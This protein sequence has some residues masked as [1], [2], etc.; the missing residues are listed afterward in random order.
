TML[1]TGCKRIVINGESYN[2]TGT[3]TQYSTNAQGCDSTVTI[4]ITINTPDI[5]V[6]QNE[7][8]L[9]A[10]PGMTYQWMDCNNGHS[11]VDGATDQSFT[12]DESGIYAVVVTGMD[13]SDTSDCYPVTIVGVPEYGIN[14][15]VLKVH[16]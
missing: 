16:P 7:S 11:P 8:T 2:A 15:D 13:C 6:T 5:S 1:D 9:T 4:D 14:R 3:Y 12:P 10:A